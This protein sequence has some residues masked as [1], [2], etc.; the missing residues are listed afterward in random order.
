MES[1]IVGSVEI[2]VVILRSAGT[3]ARASQ[4]RIT[5]WDSKAGGQMGQS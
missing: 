3:A 4:Q 5:S 2:K 1:Y